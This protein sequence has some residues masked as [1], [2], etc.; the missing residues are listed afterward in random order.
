MS[1]PAGSNVCFVLVFLA[2]TVALMFS[3][4]KR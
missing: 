4:R 2:L 1:V 3:N